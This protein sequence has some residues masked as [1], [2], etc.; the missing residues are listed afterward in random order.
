MNGPRNILIVFFA[1]LLVTFCAIAPTNDSQHVE[2][3][4]PATV[5]QG[6]AVD[7]TITGSGFE[8]VAYRNVGC[9]GSGMDLDDQFDATL[10]DSIL[11]DV[12][13]I[14]HE[15]IKARV[16]TNLPIGVYDLTLS[17]PDGTTSVLEEAFEVEGG[18]GDTDAD[19][20]TDSDS[21]S[22][23]DGDTDP[24]DG[25]GTSCDSPL[26]ID[27]D[28]YSWTGA[29]DDFGQSFTPTNDC[30][31]GDQDIWFAFH[32]PANTIVAISET[33]DVDVLIR[34]VDNCDDLLC[35]DYVDEPEWLCIEASD[36]PGWAMVVVTEVDSASVD[37]EAIVTYEHLSA[38][39]C[40]DY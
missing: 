27:E 35:V 19:S 1:A 12:T 6:A 23:S 7:I 31:S 40:D 38:S 22:D 16:P 8:P 32:R 11:M 34:L 10:D 29:W 24:Q 36:S 30:G 26:L 3:V 4:S 37:D 21:D 15:T 39:S 25:N 33:S 18:G 2:S 13:L 17:A 20:D 14:D 9:S 5:P 28:G